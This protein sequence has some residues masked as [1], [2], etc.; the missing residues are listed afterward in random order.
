VGRKAVV[1][2][3]GFVNSVYDAETVNVQ[4][5]DDIQAGDFSAASFIY[6]ATMLPRGE[7]WRNEY[8]LF[9]RSK[10]QLIVEVHERLDTL[11]VALAR[12][13]VES[14]NNQTLSI[15]AY[16]GLVC[17]ERGSDKTRWSDEPEKGERCCG[18]GAHNRGRLR[19]D[20]S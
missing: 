15:K 11:A 20:S 19:R 5:L 17:N 16:A 14:K 4:M 12:G 18:S 8:V 6:S 13:W 10:A 7:S 2:L 3:N 9:I 1:A